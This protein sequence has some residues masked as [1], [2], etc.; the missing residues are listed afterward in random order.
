M[1]NTKN[2]IPDPVATVTD[3]L[4]GPV[5]LQYCFWFY[6]F[7]LFGFVAFI[8]TLASLIVNLMFV[9]YGKYFWSFVMVKTHL[10]A[11]TFCVYFTNRLLYNMCFRTEK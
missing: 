9:N 4:F 11:M 6:V 5:A 10:L 8:L 3:Y 2:P 7:S 1:A